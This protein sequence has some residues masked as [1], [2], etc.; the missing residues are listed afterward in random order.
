MIN[1]IQ[2]YIIYEY[3]FVNSVIGFM[4]KWVIISQLYSPFELNIK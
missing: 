3:A 4:N 2:F 1:E